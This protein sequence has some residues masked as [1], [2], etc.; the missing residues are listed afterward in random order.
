MCPRFEFQYH[1]TIAASIAIKFRKFHI[2]LISARSWVLSGSKVVFTMAIQR[3]H[4]GHHLPQKPSIKQP[5]WHPNCRISKSVGD[6]S[7]GLGL[8]IHFSERGLQASRPPTNSAQRD[9]QFAVSQTHVRFIY[10]LLWRPKLK[11]SSKIELL[12]SFKST[13]HDLIISRAFY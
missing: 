6:C 4:Y 7:G 2:R 3:Q 9:C 11:K 10:R 5:L 13:S 1:R 8:G 12:T